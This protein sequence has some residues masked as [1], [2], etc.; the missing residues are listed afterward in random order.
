MAVQL[1]LNIKLRDNA[2]F[3]NYFPGA[4]RE[5]VE[6]L[7]LHCGLRDEPCAYLWGGRGT[8]KTHLLQA[9]CH[10]VAL[11]DLPTAYIP[12][13]QADELSPAILEGIAELSLVC[14]DDVHS[15]AGDDSWESALFHL[16]N[17]MRDAGTHLVVAG[18]NSP[19]SLNIRL[20]DLVSRLAWGAVFQIQPLND[21]EKLL[22]LQLHASVR[23]MEMSLDV[24]RFL[25]HR[26][27]R[28]M[29]AL[30]SLLDQLDRVSLSAQRRLTI[31][32][33]REFMIG[34]L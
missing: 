12:L 20:A 21:E 30:Y 34:R 4:N 33:I 9:A 6:Y 3:N 27:R 7:Q 16:Y 11:R 1:P 23:G 24:A 15:V 32:F 26:S 22:A 19:G 28:D 5:A 18:D 25:L 10:I 13:S 2:T 14:V 17:R 29:P 8:G 31:P